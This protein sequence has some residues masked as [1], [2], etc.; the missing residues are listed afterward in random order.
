M[1]AKAR[2]T[3]LFLV[4]IC[5]ALAFAQLSNQGKIITIQGDTIECLIQIDKD[6]FSDVVKYKRK[7]DDCLQRFPLSALRRIVVKDKVYEKVVFTKR[8]ALGRKVYTCRL[9][10]CMVD[11]FVKLYKEGIT[12]FYHGMKGVVNPHLKP[13]E[14]EVFYV[15]KS[16]GSIE[17]ID[18]RFFVQQSEKTFREYDAVVKNI[19]AA[20]YSYNDLEKIVEDCNESHANTHPAMN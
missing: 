14:R 12:M 3:L 1:I 19:R 18:S 5:P 8:N 10:L 7:K 20:K 11:G 15:A 16:D 2:I 13:Y 17:A 6:Q 9:C 4:F